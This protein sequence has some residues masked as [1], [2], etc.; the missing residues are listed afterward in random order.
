MWARS[1][2]RRAG[3][4]KKKTHPDMFLPLFLV[5][6][7]VLMLVEASNARVIK[8][9]VDGTV[10]CKLKVDGAVQPGRQR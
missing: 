1:T 9:E 2:C 10:P 8:L 5:S 6:R 4:I 7:A 3:E